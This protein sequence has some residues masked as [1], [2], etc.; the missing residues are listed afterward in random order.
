ML[1]ARE[2]MKEC[3][4]GG[5]PDRYVNNYEAI[6]LLFHPFMTASPLLQPGME[7]VK[8]AWGVTNS[9]PLG[10]PGAFPVH[11]PDKIVIQ[12]IEE[13]QKYVHAPSLEFPDELWDVFKAQYDAVDTTKSY[14]AAFVA[15]GLFEQCHHLGEIQNTLINLYEYPDEMHDLIKYLVDWEL[16]LAEGICSRLH[17]DAVFHHDDWGSQKSTFM[18][19]DMFE[20]FYVDGYKQIYKYYH[21]HGCELVIHHSDSYAATFVPAMIE[22]GIDIWQGCFE[23]NDIPTLIEKY[24]KDIS[25]MGWIENRFI[26]TA[27]ATIENTEMWANKAVDTCGM[28][29]FIPC[30]AQGGPGS[31][32]PGVYK[33]LT[34]SI[35]KINYERF[36]FTPEE[37]QA[38][39]LDWQVLF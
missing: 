38:Q 28:K 22:M 29:Y 8:N 11:T 10:V 9:F 33:Q 27:D 18:S 5:N 3:I 19:V 26:D 12:D 32:F 17:P 15:P 4:T 6:Q 24:G 14:K 37:Q 20:E 16:E 35:E 1:T 36:G 7:N 13:W 39:R 2:N 23:S 21:D 25:F 30:I 34:D 31:V